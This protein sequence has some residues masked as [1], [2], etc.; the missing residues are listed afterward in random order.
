MLG[1]AA[2]IVRLTEVPR[3]PEFELLLVNAREPELG[4]FAVFEVPRPD[5]TG[6]V[7]VEIP[8]FDVPLAIELAPRD[9]SWSERIGIANDEQSA[10]ELAFAVG[11]AS[12]RGRVLDAAGQPV[13]AAVAIQ[14]FRTAELDALARYSLRHANLGAGLA[15][16]GADGDLQRALRR[17]TGAGSNAPDAWIEP[18]VRADGYFQRDCIAGDFALVSV[19][20]G[21]P[22]PRVDPGLD[23]QGFIN[24]AREW[25]DTHRR[26]ARWVPL[27]PDGCESVDV[28]L[29]ARDEARSPVSLRA[30]PAGTLRDPWLELEQRVGERWLPVPAYEPNTQHAALE[31]SGKLPP[32]AQIRHRVRAR[33]GGS[34]GRIGCGMS[35]LPPLECWIGPWIEF[36]PNE[37]AIPLELSADRLVDW[38]G[39]EAERSAP[40]ERERRVH[41]R[42]V[43]AAGAPVACTVVLCPI[44]VPAHGRLPADLGLADELSWYADDHVESMSIAMTQGARLD[45]WPAPMRGQRTDFDGRYSFE[46]ITA[47][48][49]FVRAFVHRELGIGKSRLG[50]PCSFGPCIA[51]RCLSRQRNCQR[52]VSLA[53]AEVDVRVDFDPRTEIAQPVEVHGLAP[54]EDCYALRLEVELDGR[55]VMLPHCPV[56]D[57]EVFPNRGYRRPRPLPPSRFR[58]HAGYAWGYTAGGTN[59]IDALATDQE[60]LDAGLGAWISPHV[61]FMPSPTPLVLDLANPEVTFS[62]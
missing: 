27:D 5:A 58:I 37:R 44:E 33:D 13:V 14:T 17:C 39:A 57:G 25:R 60:M 6:R 9:R 51:D 22:G 62:D 42:V 20:R 15:P 18:A 23:L 1:T 56:E 16:F 45:V 32:L 49:V 53:G 8:R 31:W 46:R 41:G 11:R 36:V 2:A 7:V 35:Q 3:R 4:A 26:I 19:D 21:G 38:T 43:D 61:E 52:W 48:A 12:V 50:D 34:C 30:R 40:R 24:S 47:S 28:L 10:V 54:S 29:D 55:W 59:S